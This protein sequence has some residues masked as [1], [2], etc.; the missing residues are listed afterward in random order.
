[1]D[2]LW[3]DLDPDTAVNSLNQTIYFLRRVF[4]PEYREELSPGYVHHESDLL[5]LDQELVG[6]RSAD[7]AKAIRV[8]TE[9]PSPEAIERL[10]SSYEG[11]FALDFAYEDWSVAFRDSMHAAY[12]QLIESAVATDTATGQH[13][14]AI[15]L[16]RR[17]IEIDPEAEHLEVSL[18]KLYRMTGAHAA[19]AEQYEHYA[20]IQRAEIG[21]EPP[22]LESF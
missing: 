8:A 2:A 1:L 16:A 19:A 14:R 4:E 10:S 20:A 7:S 22:P 3:P 6:S 9:S 5:W 11:R 12:L 13:E 15:R 21:V 17:A 18:L